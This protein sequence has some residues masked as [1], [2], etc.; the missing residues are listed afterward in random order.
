MRHP[1]VKGIGFLF[2]AVLLASIG[3]SVIVAMLRGKAFLWSNYYG[4]PVG[5]YSTAAVL[6]VA[7]VVAIIWLFQRARR[8]FS[9]R[10][11]RR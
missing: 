4:V 9:G 6:T 5:T 2:V 1:I 7:V 8:M 3:A 11:A 10:I